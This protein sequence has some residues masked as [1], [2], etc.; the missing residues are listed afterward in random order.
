VI[1][2][3]LA[4]HRAFAAALYLIFGCYCVDRAT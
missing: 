4:T 2:L 3:K 1:A